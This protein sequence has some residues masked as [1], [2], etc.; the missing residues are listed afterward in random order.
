MDVLV[1]ACTKKR[2]D[3]IY[4]IYGREAGDEETT[5]MILDH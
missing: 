3:Y 4:R 1:E 5:C 2:K